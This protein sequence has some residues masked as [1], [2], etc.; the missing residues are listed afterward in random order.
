MVQRS[1]KEDILTCWILQ[2]DER[3][4]LIVLSYRLRYIMLYHTFVASRRADPRLLDVHPPHDVAEEEPDLAENKG[5][6]RMYVPNL[7]FEQRLLR[8]NLERQNVTRF[9]HKFV[10]VK[11]RFGLW[12][13][14]LLKFNQTLKVTRAE[15]EVVRVQL[16]APRTSR[17]RHRCVTGAPPERHQ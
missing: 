2:A 9:E 12:G 15:L 1:R 16:R 6:V 7:D 4:K 17:L 11:L 3:K 8:L 13:R 5:F 10:R 14:R